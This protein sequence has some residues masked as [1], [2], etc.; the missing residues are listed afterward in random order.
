M[1][2][3]EEELTSADDTH[4]LVKTAYVDQ[5]REAVQAEVSGWRWGRAA[6]EAMACW[7]RRRGAGARVAGQAQEKREEGERR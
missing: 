6:G 4:V 1:R 3:R 5:L 2:M 7:R